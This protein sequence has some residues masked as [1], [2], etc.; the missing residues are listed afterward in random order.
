MGVRWK[1]LG[2][3]PKIFHFLFCVKSFTRRTSHGNLVTVEISYKGASWTMAEEKTYPMTEEGK[4]KLEKELENLKTVK[5]PQII[6]RIKIARGFGDQ[7][8]AQF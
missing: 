1:V 5:R 7:N 6:E 4:T 8:H 2:I 3:I